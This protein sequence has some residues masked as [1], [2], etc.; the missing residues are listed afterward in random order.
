MI[1]QLRLFSTLLLLAVASLA[2]GQESEYYV[3]DGTITG[4]SNGYA[5]ESEISQNDVSWLVMGNTTMSPWRIGGKSIT[6][7]DRTV[8]NTT[9]IEATITKLSIEVGGASNIKVN[10]L[11]LTVASDAT[12]ENKTDEVTINFAENST[13]TFTPTSTTEWAAGSYYKITF[14][15]T[16]TSGSNRFVEF[17]KATFFHTEEGAAREATVTIGKTSMNIG[18]TTDVTTNGPALT[19]TSSNAAIASVAN[20]TVTGVAAGTATITA[21]WAE[22]TVDNVLFAAGS[23]SFDVTVVD[24]NG[25]GTENNPYTVAQARAAIDTGT[26]VKGVYVSGIVSEIVTPFNAQYGNISFNISEDGTTEAEQLQ[27]FRCFKGANNEHFE[28]ADDV[29]VGDKVVLLGNLTIYNS[30]Y[31]LEAGNYVVSLER[32]NAKES[33]GISYSASSYTATLGEA[34]EFPTLANPNNLTVTYTSSNTDV[35][36][37]SAEGNVTIVAAGTTTIKATTAEDDNYYA[38][39]ASYVL[40]VVDPNA[41]GMTADNPFTVADVL[42][43]YENNEVPANEVYVKGIISR[44]TSLNPPTYSNARYYISD[45]G[46][47]NGEFYVYNGKYLDGADFTANDQIMVG[48]EVVVYGKL[49]TYSG[50]NEFAAGNY[51]VSL[52]RPEQ[53]ETPEIL[54]QNEAGEAVTKVTLRVGESTTLTVL[55]EDLEMTFTNSDET[56]ATW[57]NGTITALA[58][59]TTTITANFAG[60]D[61]YNAA[62]ATLT[63]V[64]KEQQPVVEGKSFVKVTSESELTDGNYL[65]VYETDGLAF[66]GGLETLDAIGNTI[67]V[68][69]VENTIAANDANKAAVF[70]LAST[71]EGYTLL[72][73]SGLY[74]GQT[75]DANGL[76][77][78]EE[79]LY[80]TISF[81]EEGEANIV[82][83]GAYLR[84]NAASNQTR[85]RYYKSASYTSQKAVH[86]YKL[87]DQEPIASKVD[88]ELSFETTAFNVEPNTEFTAPVLVNPYDVTVVYS[89]SD[90]EIAAVNE[91][92]GAVT[93]GEKEGTATITASF[94][95]DETYK[96]AT[97]S[98][99]ITVKAAVVPGTDKYELVT[100]AT[101][102][103]AGDEILIAYVDDEGEGATVMGEQKSNNRA[104]VE[105]TLNADMTITPN[106]D[107]QV[108][109]L[110][111]DAEGF[112]FNVG[113]G[114]LYAASSSANQLRTETEADDNAKATIA[115]AKNE[116]TE[117]V[118]ANIVFQGSNTRNLMRFNPNNGSPIFACYSS[119]SGTG[120]LPQLYRKVAESENK[121]GDVNNDGS[122]TIADV[123]TLVNIIL[124]KNDNYNSEVADVNEDGSITIADVTTLVNI[125]LGRAN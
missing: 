16:N 23:K 49:T 120:S 37:I 123:T 39:E 71:D 95:G 110:E 13:L 10:S 6:N 17:K 80:N 41:P 82:S 92:T 112:Y 77:A 1:K 55:P 21:T 33:A 79:A 87:T 63:V 46:T 27:A 76:A 117:A 8:Y 93:I 43:L 85:F 66:N 51:I 83:G 40:S 26:G 101:T 59:G 73:A 60:N 100:D 22:G 111:G 109:K 102:L 47:Q 30:T 105:A 86:L 104:G 97:A 88:P 32:E 116:T 62:T 35:A 12:F 118:E 56:V 122:V 72:S 67:G 2:W 58:A 31:E 91:T 64:V 74:I 11:K 65:I 57:E 42:A 45:D 48:D 94:E 34:N 14:N 108:I 50:T 44:I 89:T 114:Y 18:E 15:V 96:A 7:E 107:A 68:D 29:M 19:L 99:T 54:F 28:S 36:T 78:K 125:I 90:A 106:T 81:G 3:L 24:P 61:T 53:K 38:G 98:Y 124:G 20:T 9:P 70:T 84:Y 113:N 5:S 119:T 4:G 69:I 52:N 25:P 103:K 75:S 115:I 121:K